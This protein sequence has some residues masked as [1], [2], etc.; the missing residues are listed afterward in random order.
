MPSQVE[1]RPARLP[2][3]EALLKLLK[4]ASQATGVPA[5]RLL[6]ACLARGAARKRRRAVGRT[7][8]GSGRQRRR[9]ERIPN[10]YDGKSGETGGPRTAEE[11]AIGPE[12][13]LS[14]NPS[15]DNG[16]PHDSSNEDLVAVIGQ[17]T[18]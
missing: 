2:L 11:P 12:E 3:T 7:A 13:A 18:V 4:Q 10:E 8:E 15:T 14:F 17:R 9:Q 6:L 5:A 16:E 1:G